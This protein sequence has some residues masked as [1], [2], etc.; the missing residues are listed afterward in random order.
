MKE[1]DIHMY[2]TN[3]E[4]KAVIVERFKKTLEN[5]IFVMMTYRSEQKWYDILQTVMDECNKSVHSTIK[6][7]PVEASSGKHSINFE[8]NKHT[9]PKFKIGDY[10]KISKMKGYTINWSY[11]LFRITEVLKMANI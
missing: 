8:E 11:E 4:L 1:Y 6:M 10:V 5:R 7:S 3:T 9:L 2:S